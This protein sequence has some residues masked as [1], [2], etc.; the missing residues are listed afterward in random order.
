MNRRIFVL[1]LLLASEN[2]LSRKAT[3]SL[4]TPIGEVIKAFYQAKSL[5]FNLI[6]YGDDRKWCNDIISELFKRKTIDGA[7]KVIAMEKKTMRE[8]DE[9]AI[10]FFR[11]EES[12]AEFNLNVILSRKF[13]KN[14]K[15]LMV[16]GSL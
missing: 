13:A 9:S 16:F 15:F 14:F 8:I 7:S 10:I 4:T 1:A 3:S 5:R 2:C 11:T 12:Y 6:A